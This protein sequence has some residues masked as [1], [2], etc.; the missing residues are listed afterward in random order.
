[1]SIIE[2]FVAHVNGIPAAET[3]SPEQ[4]LMEHPF[5]TTIHR[6]ALTREALGTARSGREFTRVNFNG[7]ISVTM[8]RDRHD[9][10]QGLSCSTSC[11]YKNHVF[12]GNIPLG[13]LPST[14]YAIQEDNNCVIIGGKEFLLNRCF[15]RT[16]PCTGGITVGEALTRIGDHNSCL[17]DDNFVMYFESTDHALIRLRHETVADDVATIEFSQDHQVVTFKHPFFDQDS[18][19]ECP[20]KFAKVPPCIMVAL[21]TGKSY[22]DLLKDIKVKF[23]DLFEALID[24]FVV[25]NE[26]DTKVVNAVLELVMQSS[27]VIVL[28]AESKKELLSL[29]D[30]HM[31]KL[32]SDDDDFYRTIILPTIESFTE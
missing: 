17:I 18:W 20:T 16:V 19:V 9:H 12:S 8:G 10:N 2:G 26:D 4:L 14:L 25:V 13:Y 24:L 1:M 11:C 7:V 23:K 6:R 29:F 21:M 5:C 28:E 15:H 31:D 27:S 22:D 32:W 3:L 30:E